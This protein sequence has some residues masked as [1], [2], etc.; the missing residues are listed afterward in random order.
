MVSYTFYVQHLQIGTKKLNYC[1]KLKNT[2]GLKS[3]WIHKSRAELRWVGCWVV[4]GTS[5]S[6]KQSLC[7]LNEDLNWNQPKPWITHKFINSL[8]FIPLSIFWSCP[9]C[10]HLLAVTPSGSNFMA[11]LTVS[12]ASALMEAGNLVLTASVFH[13]L[14]ENFGFCPCVLR[15]TRHSTLTRI[16][17]KFSAWMKAEN[18]DRKRRIRR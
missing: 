11:L 14:V 10:F 7:K 3:R 12:T 5:A 17:Q 6:Q 8:V 18:R 13:G 2:N 1:F 15:V 4:M 9:L 16:A